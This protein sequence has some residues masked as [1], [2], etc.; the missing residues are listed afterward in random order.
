MTTPSSSTRQRTTKENTRS[1]KEQIKIREHFEK[2]LADRLTK[3]FGGVMKIR[4]GDNDIID[5][6]P[7]R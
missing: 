3:E 4:R 2:K 1:R 5:I 6:T 7:N